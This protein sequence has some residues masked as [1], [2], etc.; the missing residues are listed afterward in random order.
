MLKGPPRHAR[1]R[2]SHVRDSDVPVG[3]ASRMKTIFR[4]IV[5]VLLVVGWGLA[6][7]SLHV[8]RTPDEIPITLVPRAQFGVTDPYVD[9]RHWTLDE[10]AQHPAVVEKLIESGKA[11]VLKHV[12]T[13][14][15]A[16]DVSAQLNEALQ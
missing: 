4:L 7:L 12:V 8:I 3:E 15:K 1:Q 13:D 11:D 9:T 6:A 16:G 2:G 10:A 5:L 14:A